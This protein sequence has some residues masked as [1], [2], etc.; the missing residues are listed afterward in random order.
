M[1]TP[2]K[3]TDASSRPA[4]RRFTGTLRGGIIAVGSETTGWQLETAPGQRVDLDASRA[5]GA[6]AALEGK[7]V[8]VE[9]SMTTR[10]WIERGPKPLLIA[11]RIEAAE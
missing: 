1:P 8:V 5:A 6:A 4:P 10:R 2:S 3:A 9:G 11:D 7:P